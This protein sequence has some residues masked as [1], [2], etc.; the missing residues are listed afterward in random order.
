MARRHDGSSAGLI[1]ATSWRSAD[2]CTARKMPKKHSSA[3]TIAY[4]TM[5]AYWTPV[6]WLM[7]KA[8]DP[9]TGGMMTPPVEAAASTA[10]ANCAGQCA[11]DRYPDHPTDET[12]RISG[13]VRWGGGGC[14]LDRWGDH[15]A[16]DGLDRLHHESIHG[17]P[18]C[19]HRAVCD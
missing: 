8:I 7:M 11:H 17:Y 4:S 15:A 12:H 6:Y 19:P 14:G 1:P 10:P 9:I 16:G 18:V 5:R 3:G 2:Q 13:A